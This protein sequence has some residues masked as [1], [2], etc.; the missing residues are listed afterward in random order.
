MLHFTRA[1]DLVDVTPGFLHSAQR[2]LHGLNL[3][4]KYAEAPLRDFRPTRETY[5]LICAQWVLMYLSDRLF[6]GS[7]RV[8]SIL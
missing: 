2:L 6:P 3:E 8:P 1:V 4:G 5:D 7:G